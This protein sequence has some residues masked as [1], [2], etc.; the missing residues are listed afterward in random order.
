MAQNEFRISSRVNAPAEAVWERAT[1][2]E[3]INA[4]LMPIVRMTLP[5]G[6]GRLDPES[7]PIGRRI[8][9]SWILL[10]GVLPIDFDDI[11][12]VRLDPGRGFLERS[13]M[14][15]QRLWEHERT[16]EP[17]AA[18]ASLVTD[19]VRFEPKLR[20]PAGTL[21]PLFRTV[22]RHR[23]RRLRRHFGGYLESVA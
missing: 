6:V 9:R 23:H 2:A 12:L 8:G 16:I 3:G 7:V 5:R 18:G 20:L 1:T 11:T 19:R 14:L 4:E 21:T 17:Q 10:F 22:F 15:T 13:P